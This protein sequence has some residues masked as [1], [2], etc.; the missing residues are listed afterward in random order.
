MTEAGGEAT[1][2]HSA[3]E[4]GRWMASEAP[5]VPIPPPICL[6]ACPEYPPA[7]SARYSWRSS[8]NRSPELQLNGPRPAA[9]APDDGWARAMLSSR[10]AP[11]GYVVASMIMDVEAEF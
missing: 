8:R 9:A 2:H 5:Q 11:C 1:F 3:L 6:P 10:W 4:T 7:I